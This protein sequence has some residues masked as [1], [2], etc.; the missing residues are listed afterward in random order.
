M[1]CLIKNIPKNFP[2]SL[3]NNGNGFPFS[4]STAWCSIA[5][6][7]YLILEESTASEEYSLMTQDPKFIEVFEE[8]IA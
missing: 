7:F 5:P 2:V 3:G 1:N 8:D 6:D 4:V